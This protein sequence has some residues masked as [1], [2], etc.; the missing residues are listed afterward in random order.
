M[1]RLSEYIQQ[2][3]FQPRRQVQQNNKDWGSTSKES[4]ILMHAC[5]DDMQIHPVNEQ[6]LTLEALECAAA[7]LLKEVMQWAVGKIL[8]NTGETSTKKMNGCPV[9]VQDIQ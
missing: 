2:L 7:A 8:F 9:V 1:I 4:E 6:N 5:A 3:Q